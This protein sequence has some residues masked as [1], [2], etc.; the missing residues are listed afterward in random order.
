[1]DFDPTR[2]SLTGYA[3]SLELAK[4]G[5]G[6]WRFSTGFDT[7]SPGFEVNDLGFQRNADRTIQWLWVNRRWL[8]PGK[9][10][11]DFH[12]NVNQWGVWNYGWDKNGLG[13]N[14]NVNFTLRNYWSGYAGAGRWAEALSTGALRGGPAIVRPAGLETWFGFESDERKALRGGVNG[15]YS[16]EQEKAGWAYGVSPTVSWRPATNMDF[17][18]G[19]RYSRSYNAWQYLQSAE[20]FGDTHYVFGRLDQRTFGMTFRGNVTFTSNISLQ[21]YAEPFVSSGRYLGFREVADPRAA[22]FAGRFTDFT[23]EQL[24]PG[25]DGS[26]GVDLNDDG[27][28]DLALGSPDF[29]FL[30]FRSNVVLRWEYLLGSTMFLVWQHGRSDV[31]N[32]GTFRLGRVGDLFDAEQENTFVVKFSYYLSM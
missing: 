28:E 10:F 26:V 1:M 2:T 20:A 7:R 5:G 31:R 16:K 23:P 14:V 12:L 8:Q 18:V 9:V 17:R 6:N 19:P 30:S 21:L 25:E 11:R 24:V 13:A 29:T 22:T 15:W 3:A 32:D 4:H 27:V